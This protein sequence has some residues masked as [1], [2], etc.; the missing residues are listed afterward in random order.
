MGAEIRMGGLTPLLL[1]IKSRAAADCALLGA[2]GRQWKK[3]VKKKILFGGHLAKSSI[4][5]LKP[6]GRPHPPQSGDPDRGTGTAAALDFDS[7]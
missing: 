4:P 1:S 6:G 7:L 2:S 5:F 3:V